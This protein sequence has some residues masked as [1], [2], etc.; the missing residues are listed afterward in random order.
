MTNIVGCRR[1]DY[2]SRRSNQPVRGYSFFLTEKQEGVIGLATYDV[3]L[4]DERS[5]DFL[6]HFKQLDDCLGIEVA[7][8]F[9]RYGRPENIA[10]V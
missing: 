5:G 7:V 8:T 1:V 4:S 10:I 3:F 2:V 6:S 9:N